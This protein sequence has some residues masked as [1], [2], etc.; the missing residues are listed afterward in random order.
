MSSVS[1]EQENMHYVV[2][3]NI[4]GNVDWRFECLETYEERYFET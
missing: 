3:N 2:D 4:N 1:Y